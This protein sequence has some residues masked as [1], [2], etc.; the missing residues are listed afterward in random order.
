MRIAQIAPIIERVPAKKYGGTERV[1]YA[2]TE[3]LVRRGHDVTL[4]ATGNSITSAKLVSV[5]P[6]GLRESKQEDRYGRNEWGLLNF[7]LA[8][9][10]QSEF[11]IIHDHNILTSLPTANI[12]RTPVVMTLHDPDHYERANLELYKSMSNVNLVAISK[13]QKKATPYLNF[14]GVVYNG[15]EM[16]SYPFSSKDAGYLL[17]VGRIS[18]MKGVH[19]AITV[20]E[21]LKKPLLIAAR[22]E[23]AFIHDVQY[24]YEYIEPK[25]SDNI[26]WIGEVDEKQR[27]RLMSLAFC[28]LHPV[29]TPEPFGL[30]IIESMACGSPVIGFDLGSLPELIVSGETG[31]VVKNTDEM[32]KAVLRVKKIDRRRCR[33]HVLKNFNS[34]RMADGYERIYYQLVS[35]SASKYPVPG[36]TRLQFAHQ[37]TFSK[38]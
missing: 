15:L 12:S 1:I 10:S 7:G 6:N 27:N 23:T 14:A 21:V 31:F 36:S 18:E 28:T 24:F 37:I 4:F 19:H 8:Y 35:R 9:N 22:L 29:T 13:A 25:L 16:Q 34:R 38:K 30:T 11:D 33:E 3:E 5:Y 32:I 20:A 26:V 2:L 17:F